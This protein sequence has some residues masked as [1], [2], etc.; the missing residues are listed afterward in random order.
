MWWT[1][2]CVRVCAAVCERRHTKESQKAKMNDKGES[3]ETGCVWERERVKFGAVHSSIWFKRLISPS[4]PPP[5]IR[6][7]WMSTSLHCYDTQSICCKLTVCLC[8]G[9]WWCW[10]WQWWCVRICLLLLSSHTH[11]HSH[12][13]KALV[14]PLLSRKFLQQQK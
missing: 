6:A 12:K 9:Y 4:L 14:A 2:F 11:T 8:C 3:R 10:C 13:K 7:L 5:R 1:E